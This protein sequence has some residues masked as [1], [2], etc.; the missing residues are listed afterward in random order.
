MID[1]CLPDSPIEVIPPEK[2][3]LSVLIDRILPPEP[4]ALEDHDMWKPILLAEMKI[5]VLFHRPHKVESAWR[6][7]AIAA[8]IVIAAAAAAAAAVDDDD[9]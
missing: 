1:V 9:D 3:P 8:G 6:R 2:V 4:R 7:G 5:L